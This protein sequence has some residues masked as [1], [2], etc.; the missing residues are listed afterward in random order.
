MFSASERVSRTVR[1]SASRMD[2]T[3]GTAG[4][5]GAAGVVVV[6]VVGLVAVEVCVDA[7][8]ICA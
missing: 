3:G 7:V 2:S 8:R 5:T 6:V 1:L 4:S